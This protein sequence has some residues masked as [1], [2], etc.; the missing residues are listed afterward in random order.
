VRLPSGPRRI[1]GAAGRGLRSLGYAAQDGFFVI[2][3]IPRA[4]GRGAKGFWFGLP[5]GSRRRLAI[6]ALG[7]VGLVLL[8]A[9]LVPRLPCQFPGGDVC[10]PPDDAEVVVPA[11]AL[12]YVHVTLDPERSQ[13]EDAAEALDVLPQ[14]TRQVTSRVLEQVPGPEGG[15]AN[16]EQDIA[17]W[18]GGQAAVAIVPVGGGAEQVQLL[19]E[20]DPGRADEFATSLAA[21]TP[22]VEDYRGIDVATDTR[23]LATASVEGFLAIGTEEGVRRVVDVATGAEDSRPLSEEET[24]VELRDDLPSD[25]F[26]EAYV[27]S[28]GIE[29][30]IADPSST[31]SSLEPFVDAAASEGAAASLGADDGSLEVAVRSALDPERA[32]SNPGFFAAFPSFEPS[33]PER[34]ARRTLGYVGLAEP[35]T[36]VRE[37]LAQATAEAPALAAGITEAAERLRDLG[38]VELEDELLPSLGGEAAFALQPGSGQPSATEPEGTT[39]APAP[40]PEGLPED[41]PAPPGEPVPILQFLAEG[42]D[43]ERARR[44]LAQL[45]VPISEAFDTGTSLQAPVFDRREVGG[46][47]MQVLGISP[48]VNLSYAVAGEDLA[49]ATQPQGVEEVVAGEGG[50]DDTEAFQTA[51]EDLAEEPSLLAY[52]DLSGLLDLAEREGLAEDPAYALFAGE[53]RRLRGAGLSVASEPSS[54]DTD[55]R[56]VVNQDDEEPAEDDVPAAP[57][58]D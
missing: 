10:A 36:T 41:T 42:V 55:L 18:L 23:G 38:D 16:F 47:E 32:K 7:A 5:V 31:L 40:T 43:S 34:L 13:Y 57:S 37:L 50:L 14:L 27:S 33:L 24:A 20:G 45:Q 46:V 30:L 1:A 56:I 51:T 4:I 54:I 17:P 52:L 2:A 53:L 19:E 35:G 12:G 49:V 44:T 25:R 8:L 22:R 6:V 3:R 26:L 28:D 39:T 9:F 11:D 48:T 29:T 58:E 21:G 15:A